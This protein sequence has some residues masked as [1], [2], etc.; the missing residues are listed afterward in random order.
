MS[1]LQELEQMRKEI[2]AKIAEAKAAEV[3]KRRD[4]VREKLDS[5]TKEQKEFILSMMDHGRT[6]CSDDMPCNG[7]SYSNNNWRCQKCM[8]IEIF[9]EEHGTDFD[10]KISAEIY[11]VEPLE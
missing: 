9:N 6:S 2:D 10:F 1:T 5:L 11:P 3:Q 7:F 8:M 4:H